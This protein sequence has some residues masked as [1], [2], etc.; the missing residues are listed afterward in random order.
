MMRRLVLDLAAFKA[1]AS[2]R[3]LDMLKHLDE[4]PMTVSELARVTGLAKASVHEHLGIL[5]DADI[6]TRDETTKRKWVYYRLTWKGQSI[7]HP[8]RRQVAIFLA[9]ASTLLLGAFA[10]G[11]WM[12]ADLAR[13]TNRANGAMEGAG[14]VIQDS[15]IAPLVPVLSVIIVGLALAS[16]ALALL[17]AWD[18][19]RRRERS[20]VDEF[21][22]ALK[23]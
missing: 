16:S 11:L 15:D 21:R 23:D 1:L 8:E 4:R 12:L 5:V 19:W 9:F 14:Y 17:L 10:Y 20:P 22:D 13:I 3:R 7:V 2:D 18:S 6:V